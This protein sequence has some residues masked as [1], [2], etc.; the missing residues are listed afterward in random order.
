MVNKVTLSFDLLG[1]G[2]LVVSFVFQLGFRSLT[3]GNPNL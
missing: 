1:F 2:V 3:R